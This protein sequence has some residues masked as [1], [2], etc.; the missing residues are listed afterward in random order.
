MLK[1]CSKP[2]HLCLFPVYVYLLS[3]SDSSL[4][5]QTA[6]FS[7]LSSI[8]KV[9]LYYSYS[10]ICSKTFRDHSSVG[11]TSFLR[12]FKEDYLTSVLWEPM[13][14]SCCYYYHLSCDNHALFIFFDDFLFKNATF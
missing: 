10:S 12:I 1:G 7:Y 5:Q 11:R 8:E 14:T 3:S 9:L 6:Y 13:E 4:Q 2:L